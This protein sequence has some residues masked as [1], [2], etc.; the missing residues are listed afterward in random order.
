MRSITQVSVSKSFPDEQRPVLTVRASYPVFSPLDTSAQERRF[1]D[2]ANAFY[3]SAATRLSAS[4][5]RKDLRIAAAKSAQNGAVCTYSVTHTVAFAGNDYVSTF[6]HT[7]YFDGRHTQVWRSPALWSV[8]HAALLPSGHVFRITRRTR[9]R[10]IGSI[11]A[12]LEQ[13]LRRRLFTYYDNYEALVRGHFRFSSFYFVPNGGA[14][15]FDGGVLGADTE[16]SAVFV[17]PKEELFDILRLYPS[18]WADEKHDGT[19]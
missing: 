15:C 10:V 1:T 18:E 3:K 6:V 7:A 16:R 13:N 8:P 17:L 12:Q 11:L 14:F 19:T 2:T 9:E 5:N 4:V